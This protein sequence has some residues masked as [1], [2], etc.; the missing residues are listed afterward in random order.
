VNT[1]DVVQ[2]APLWD[3]DNTLL[4]PVLAQQIV[5]G[6]VRSAAAISFTDVDHRVAAGQTGLEMLKK[7]PL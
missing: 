5:E 4:A 2:T 7:V 1:H 3:L 6:V